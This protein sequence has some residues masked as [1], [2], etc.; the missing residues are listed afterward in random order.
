MPW[1]GCSSWRAT[2]AIR[3]YAPARP[4]RGLG[5]STSIG[6]SVPTSAGSLCLGTSY[7]TSPKHEAGPLERTGGSDEALLTRPR[8]HSP[9]FALTAFSEVRYPQATPSN[10]KD[11]PFA[12]CARNHNL[13]TL[14][15]V[16]PGRGLEPRL[17]E[18]GHRLGARVASGATG[19]PLRPLCT[20]GGRGILRSSP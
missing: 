1:Q 16:R 7:R 11:A 18:G 20:R 5:C 15:H 8:S 6:R 10:N 9:N 4:S 2:S 12:G 17:G 14:S 3:S 13:G 19:C